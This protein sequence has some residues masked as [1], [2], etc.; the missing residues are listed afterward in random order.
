MDGTGPANALMRWPAL[1]VQGTSH[2]VISRQ[3]PVMKSTREAGVGHDMAQ[4]VARS[5]STVKQSSRHASIDPPSRQ[6]PLPLSKWPSLI[7]RY[8]VHK[9]FPIPS[10]HIS[11]FNYMHAT[12]FHASQEG[13]DGSSSKAIVNSNG[14]A[15]GIKKYDAYHQGHA[16]HITTQRNV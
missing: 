4:R 12:Q 15:G 5:S 10:F 16:L 13:I 3:G 7:R 9:P 8:L 6:V 2:D 1:E 14:R 11:F